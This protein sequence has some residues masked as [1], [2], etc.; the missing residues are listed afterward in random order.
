[1][2]DRAF[3]ENYQAVENEH[4]KA[5]GKLSPVARLH[6]EFGTYEVGSFGAVMDAAVGFT[7]AAKPGGGVNSAMFVAYES[8]LGVEI[9]IEGDG[10]ASEKSQEIGRVVGGFSRAS[11]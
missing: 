2:F 6:T 11:R 7:I 8:I 1:M 10:K 3:F 9:T 4:R 5:R